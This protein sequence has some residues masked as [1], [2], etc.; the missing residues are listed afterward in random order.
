MCHQ[1]ILSQELGYWFW[2]SGVLGR[3]EGNIKGETK[4]LWS[5]AECLVPGQNVLLNPP[6]ELHMY[7]EKQWLVIKHRTELEGLSSFPSSVTYIVWPW[8]SHLT[9]LCL[10]LP[11]CKMQIIPTSWGIV[12]LNTLVLKTFELRSAKL[13]YCLFS[14]S[15]SFYICAAIAR[16]NRII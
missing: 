12:R 3:T 9:S 8:A 13:L 1:L 6:L 7:N 4:G 16:H 15:G 2:V 10:I 11:I 14:N 5:H